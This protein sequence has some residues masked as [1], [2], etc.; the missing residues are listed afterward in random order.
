MRLFKRKEQAPPVKPMGIRSTVTPEKRPT[1]F[2]E[3]IE[4]REDEDFERIWRDFKHQIQTHR[5]RNL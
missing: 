4:E 5:T 3:W 2:N 1:S